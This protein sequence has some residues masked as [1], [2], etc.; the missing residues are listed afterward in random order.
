M[1]LERLAYVSRSTAPEDQVLAF[2]DI[3]AQS[4]RNNRADEVTGALTFTPGRYAQI[5]EG[6][7]RALDTLLG[8]ISADPRHCDMRI[9]DRGPIETRLFPEWSM[10]APGFSPDGR[11]RLEHMLAR[12]DVS[13]R[14]L[15]DLILEMLV[16]GD[17]KPDPM[18]D[19]GLV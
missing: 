6:E 5:L 11:T 1:P 15:A 14:Q 7:G 12:D 10:I 13:M 9:L 16:P 8:R 17:G 4:V 2:S 3:L 19:S 18:A